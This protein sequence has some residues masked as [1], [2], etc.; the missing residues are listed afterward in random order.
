MRSS[1]AIVG[2]IAGALG[3]RIEIEMVLHVASDV[4]KIANDRHSRGLK[5]VCG[6]ETGKLQQPRRSY[7]AATHD[8]LP[9]GA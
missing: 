9:L 2:V 4:R 3:D 6:A 1:D 7:R 5:R 8:H